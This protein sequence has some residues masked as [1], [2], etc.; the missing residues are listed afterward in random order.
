M[1]KFTPHTE[2]NNSTVLGT[3]K[4]IMMVKT[5]HKSII[6]NFFLVIATVQGFILLKNDDS[7]LP[8]AIGSK[9][10]VVGPHAISTKGLLEDYAGD[11]VLLVVRNVS[12]F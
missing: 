5:T 12:F 4:S 3:N 10:A 8:L 11:E 2:L 9:V 1:A 7:V 6:L